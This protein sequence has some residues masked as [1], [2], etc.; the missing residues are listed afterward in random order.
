MSNEIKKRKKD[1]RKDLVFLRPVPSVVE[2]FRQQV[3]DRLSVCWDGMGRDVLSY[4]DIWEVGERKMEEE[5]KRKE[6]ISS[7]PTRR[8]LFSS[9]LDSE[10]TS[11]PLSSPI[12]DSIVVN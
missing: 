9:S 10:L 7:A 6:T 11:H 12:K 3:E 2:C 1:E 8:V 5:E 4:E